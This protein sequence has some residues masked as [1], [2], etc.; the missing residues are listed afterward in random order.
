METVNNKPKI[1]YLKGD[2]NVN[3]SAGERH[4]VALAEA[5]QQSGYDVVVGCIAGSGLERVLRVTGIIVRPVDLRG[6]IGSILEI[7]RLCRDERPDILHTTGFWTNNVGRLGGRLARVPIILSTVHCEPDSTI[8]FKEGFIRRL[9]RRLR[10]GLDRFTARF[11]RLIIVVSGNIQKKLIAMRIPSKKIVVIPNAVSPELTERLAGA[12]PAVDLPSAKLIGCIGRLEPVKGV[13]YLIDACAFLEREGLDFS[14]VIVGDGP[15]A[16]EL[17]ADAKRAA[18]SNKIIFTGRLDVAD[19]LSVLA[20]LDVYVLPSLSEGLNTTLL[21]ALVLERPVVATA[22]GGNPEVIVDGQTGLLV[23]PKDPKA[24]AR[25]ISALLDDQL[26]GEQM[27]AR[28]RK[29]VLEKYSIDQMIG[30]TLGLYHELL[31]GKRRKPL[32]R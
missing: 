19:A 4:L 5:A 12:E 10:N 6:F 7:R 22:V 29:L 24:L 25:A 16:N 13:N 14:A 15:M 18:V 1:F 21:E 27:A 11:A 20:R 30:R 2:K 9:S 3:P 8:Q 17:E 32:G 26:L 31:S 23:P 28:G